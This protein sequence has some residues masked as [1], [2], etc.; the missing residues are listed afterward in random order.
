V[1]EHVV[2][3][4]KDEDAPSPMAKAT[5]QRALAALDACGRGR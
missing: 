4:V 2:G 3:V 1:D 5:L